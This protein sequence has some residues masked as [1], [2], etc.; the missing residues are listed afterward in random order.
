[1]PPPASRRRRA[2]SDAV[3]TSLPDTDHWRQVIALGW[4][5]IWLFGVHAHAPAVRVDGQGLVLSLAWSNMLGGRLET[6]TED[7]AAIRYRSGSLLTYRC[8]ARGLDAS[9]LWWKCTA[10]V[11]GD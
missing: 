10:I 11:G 3:H 9:G 7:H 8:G 4:P 5:L 2:Q 1:M 6:I